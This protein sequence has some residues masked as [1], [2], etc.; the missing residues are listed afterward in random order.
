MLRRG[1]GI[2]LFTLFG[3]RI[4]ADYSW[5][6][7][8][9][10]IATS[11]AVGWF[12]T[13]IPHRTELAYALLGLITALFFF[14][15]VLVHELAHSV[16]AV[17]SGIPVRKITLFLFG[18]VAEIMREPAD[19]GTELRVALAGPVTSAAIAAVL[20]TA[21]ALMGSASARP[22][23][24]LAIQYLAMANTV[25]LA[26]NLLPGLPLDG[27]RVLR[28]LIWRARGS[29]RRATRAASMAGKVIAGLLALAGVGFV[30]MA[31]LMGVQ[32]REAII[33]GLWFIFIALFLRQAA[34]SSYRQVLVREALAGV[35]I[36]SVMVTDPVSVPSDITL[37]DLIE[38]YLLRHHYTAYPVVD[39]DVPL[40]VVSVALVK[41]VPRDRW[42][43]TTVS[44][45]M[46]PLT[47]DIALAPEDTL[48]TAIGKM[49][50]SGLTKLPVMRDG[51]L[52]GVVTKRDIATYLEIRSDLTG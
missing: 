12:P 27:G 31:F 21:Y 36:S 50:A 5:F 32:A 26:F 45:A 20:W 7:I 9:A 38:R 23:L 30:V 37:S 28:A 42:R 25:L 51:R 14:A 48:P 34:D 13:A 41:S 6:L 39:G 3:I 8:V 19:A 47:D 46:R 16:V 44:Q 10:L 33:P 2:S 24:R 52:I 11:L 35:A 17:R 40:G 18:G 29:L 4:V 1:R 43:S 15:S 49:S 22:G